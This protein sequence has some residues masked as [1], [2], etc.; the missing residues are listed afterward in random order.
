MLLG[1]QASSDV[2]AIG[3]MLYAMLCGAPPFE[4][5]AW[6]EYFFLHFQYCGFGMFIPDLNFAIPRSR[7]QIRKTVQFVECRLSVFFLLL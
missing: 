2:W 3:C 1:H 4:T 5:Q 7:I 6:G